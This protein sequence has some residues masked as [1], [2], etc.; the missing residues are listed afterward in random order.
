MPTDPIQILQPALLA[1]LR[2]NP[3]HPIRLALEENDVYR[4]KPV[5]PLRMYECSGDMDVDPANAQ[6]ALASFQALGAAQ[7]QLIDPLPGADHTTCA[8]PSLLAAKSW[9]DSL[10]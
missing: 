2:N 1:A 4:W 6:V 10:R 7:V 3:R 8:E 5:C 9:F